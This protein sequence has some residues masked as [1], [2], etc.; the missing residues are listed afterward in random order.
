[1]FASS[2]ISCASAPPPLNRPIAALLRSGYSR[3]SQGL[4]LTQSYTREPFETG[5][6][7]AAAVEAQNLRLSQHSSELA[8][9]FVV[10]SIFAFGVALTTYLGAR[11]V[12][13][14]LLTV[15]EL[16]RF[17][18]ILAQLYE[19]LNQLSHVGATVVGAFAGARRIF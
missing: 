13:I 10:A 9:G 6:F 18:L 14:G 2:P 8:Y 4:L 1:M 19:P 17:P 11:Q 7:D 12:A 3:A 16:F 15:G 5:R